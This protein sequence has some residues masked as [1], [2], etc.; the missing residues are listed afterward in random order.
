[1]KESERS[2]GAMR[3]DGIPGRVM[4]DLLVRET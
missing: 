4:G 1:M 3:A 2:V